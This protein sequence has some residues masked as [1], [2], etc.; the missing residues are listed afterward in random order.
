[1]HTMPKPFRSG[2]KLDQDQ[3]FARK[4][5]GLVRAAST[6][7][8]SL[9]NLYVATFPI[10][11]SFLLGIVLPFYL[12]AN[13]YVTVLIGFALS[14]PILVTYAV[15]SSV[16]RR[17]GGDYVFIGRLLHPAL[18]FAAN[19]AFV[20]FNTLFLTSAGYFFCLWCLSPLSRLLGVAFDSSSLLT[21][22]DT[23]LKPFS[24]L[25]VSE[26]F[27]IG[28]GLLFMLNPTRSILK[29]FRY[30]IPVSLIGLLAFAIA[31]LIHSGHTLHAN[32]DN[33][34]ADA[35][36]VRNATAA[37]EKSS[38]FSVAPFALGATLLAVTWPSFSLPYYLGSAYFAG[39]VRNARRAQL[40]A[41]PVTAVVAVIGSLILIWLS[42]GKLGGDF[43][44]ALASTDPAAIGLGGNPTYM[45][46]AAGSSGSTIL[47]VLIL[48]GFGSWLVPTVPMSL[49]I[50]TRCMFGWSMD[51]IAPDALAKVSPRT[52]S[53]Y[54]AVGVVTLISAVISYFWAYTDFFTVVVGAF[55]QIITLGIGCLAA[56]LLPFKRKDL[57]E[58]APIRGHFGP[59]P[60]LTL[61]GILGA[62]GAALIVVNFARDPSSGV[63]PSAAPTMFWVSL[64]MFPA[65]F[66]LYY[67]SAAIRRRQGVDLGL[68]FKEIPPE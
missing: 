43:L 31:L 14:L 65:G 9:V 18:G 53:P 47:G 4:S 63:N 25:V 37:A 38:G 48:V 64:A 7:D 30:T 41:G 36:G 44:G 6:T 39:E 54:V 28:F 12:G 49:L 26:I 8:A 42:L 66:V 32:F 34:I 61:I 2:A 35:T 3:V 27:V 33:Y 11:V 29:V 51:R 20:V 24:I 40:L 57:Y 21:F 10:M 58:T 56:S 68:A 50:M 13:L 55:A 62:I 5:S 15:A 45:E 67:V 22:S 60:K 16:M 19:F 1:M 59:I 17:S 23:L 46:V 52:G